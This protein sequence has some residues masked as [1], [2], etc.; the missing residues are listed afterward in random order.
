MSEGIPS[1]PSEEYQQLNRT[2]LEKVLDRAA[3]D[4]ECRRLLRDDPEATMQAAEFPED[5]RLQEMYQGGVTLTREALPEATA[6][7]S[8]AEE[9][10][11]LQDSLRETILLRHLLRGCTQADKAG[12][13][14]LVEGPRRA[15]VCMAVRGFD[16]L[17]RA[18]GYK[19][20]RGTDR[21]GQR[22]CRG[23]ART[24]RLDLGAVRS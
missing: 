19:L 18:V 15:G 10:R 7:T 5:R 24:T 20:D 21:S 12:N 23:S 13:A 3:N 14:V 9:Y 22:A 6:P 1:N 2:L 16:A 11:Q 17:G 8:R 4:S